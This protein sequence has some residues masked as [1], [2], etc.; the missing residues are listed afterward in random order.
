[1]NFLTINSR[2]QIFL[3]AAVGVKGRFKMRGRTNGAGFSAAFG[4]FEK[5]KYSKSAL[6][7]TIYIDKAFEIC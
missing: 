4:L 5:N 6:Y 7:R 3:T 2:G 1:M